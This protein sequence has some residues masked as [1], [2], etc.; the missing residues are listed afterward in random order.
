MKFAADEAILL[1]LSLSI[2]GQRLGEFRVMGVTFLLFL[3]GVI[4]R[5]LVACEKA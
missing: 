5:I 1:P 4:G 2:T 3:C